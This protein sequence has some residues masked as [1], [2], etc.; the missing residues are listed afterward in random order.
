M[1]RKNNLAILTSALTFSTVSLLTVGIAFCM[2][3]PIL[4]APFVAVMTYGVC[5]RE[6]ASFE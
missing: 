6:E 2:L 4:V 5:S 1:K 3:L